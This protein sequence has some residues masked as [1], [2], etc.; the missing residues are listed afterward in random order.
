[1]NERQM[2]HT[3][4]QAGFTRA[5]SPLLA[6]NFM[7][8]VFL[9]TTAILSGCG[10]SEQSKQVVIDRIAIM[11]NLP[12]PFKMM[13]WSEQAHHY[14]QYVFN[15]DLKGE[16]MP[17]IWLDSAKRNT[18]Q[19]TFGLYTVIGDVR[20]GPKGS[21]EFHEALCTMGSLLGAGLVGIDKTNQNGFNYVKMTQN[22]FNS[23]NGWN[24]MMNTP[25]PASC[26]W[27]EVM[28]AIG[29][30]MFFQMYCT[31]VFAICFHT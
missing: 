20:Q 2:I 13:D 9:F 28:A 18:P 1:M 19:N 3:D 12:E 16:N 4:F 27:V 8:M 29:G 25:T 5:T 30:T 24:I 31:T 10:Q 7:F 21:K 17:F 23:A 15:H 22:Y 26:Y 6:P 11:P 14:D